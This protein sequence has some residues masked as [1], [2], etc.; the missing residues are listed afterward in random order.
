[1]KDAMG[2]RIERDSARTLAEKCIEGITADVRKYRKY[3]E[4]SAALL[5]A[6]APIIGYEHAARLVKRAMREEKS[7]RQIICEDRLLST[8]Q[9]DVILNLPAPIPGRGL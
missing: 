2:F 4:A 3:A 9:I 1:M 7:I 5:P 8:E 6:L